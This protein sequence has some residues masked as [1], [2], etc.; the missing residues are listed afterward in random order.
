MRFEQ[1][2]NIIRFHE[3]SIRIHI[4]DSTQGIR[5]SSGSGLG[6]LSLVSRK[7]YIHFMQVHFIK[8]QLRCMI[9]SITVGIT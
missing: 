3:G 6:H 7:L 8:L 1:L 4:R 9:Y 5:Q 2:Q